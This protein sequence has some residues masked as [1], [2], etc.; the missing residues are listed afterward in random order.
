MGFFIMS[1]IKIKSRARTRINN[2]WRSIAISKLSDLGIAF[3]NQPKNAVLEYLIKEHKVN[4]ISIDDLR[5]DEKQRILDQRENEQHKESTKQKM[6]VSVLPNGDKQGYT[7]KLVP[8]VEHKNKTSKKTIAKKPATSNITTT[9]YIKPVGYIS[10]CRKDEPINLD[11]DVFYKSWR[12]R[13]LR[14]IV[15]DVCGRYCCSCG[16]APRHGNKV[17]LN[18]DHIQPLRLHPELA[19]DITNLQVLCEACNQGKSWFNTK[20]YRTE[21]QRNKM[22]AMKLSSINITDG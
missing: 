4:I 15:L 21:E 18:V 19:L 3:D 10:R 5:A 11:P 13:E 22:I 7:V 8:A 20:D 12:W 16:E 17:V 14:L 9:S 1:R 6:T 2:E